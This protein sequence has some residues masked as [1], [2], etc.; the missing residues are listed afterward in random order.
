MRSK[1][2]NYNIKSGNFKER[3]KIGQYYSGRLQK[4]KSNNVQLK[5]S[6]L[7]KE[8]K[9]KSKSSHSVWK[10]IK[11]RKQKFW[12]HVKISGIKKRILFHQPFDR[13]S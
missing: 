4:E 5:Y 13:G 12:K 11:I 8:I 10:E 1:S 9:G 2:Q 3:V 7:K 6:K